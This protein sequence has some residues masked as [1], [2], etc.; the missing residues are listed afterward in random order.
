MASIA[1]ASW[2]RNV[3]YRS[4]SEHHPSLG[5]S[6]HKVVKRNTPGSAYDPASLNFTHGVASGDPYPNS[7]ILWTRVGPT[8]D[9]DHSNVTVSG[10]A[11]LFNHDTEKYVKVSKA[12]ICVQYK[13]SEDK[14][15]AHCA[16]EGTVFTS[17][18]IDYTVKVGINGLFYLD[19]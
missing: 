13:I 7:V 15:L 18:D 12:P 14:D 1:S 16:D 17:S 5:I 6:I 3:N 4:P 2:T 10:Y 19:F 9:N 8:S 11:G